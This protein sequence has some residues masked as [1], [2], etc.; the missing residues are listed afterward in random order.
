MKAG[1]NER[2]KVIALGVLILVAI[3]VWFTNRGES[4]PPVSSTP[5][6]APAAP[7]PAARRAQVASDAVVPPRTAPSRSMTRGGS[8]SR[9]QEF[10]PS[11]KPR[12]PDERI[13][14]TTIDPTLRLEL[15]AKLQKVT[16]QGSGRSLF[17]FAA[18]PVPKTPEPK[19]TLNPVQKAMEQ[20]ASGGGPAPGGEAVKPPPPPIPLKFYGYTNPSR[21]G[22][23][24]AFFLDGDDILVA[25]EGEVLKRRYKVVRIGISSAV[26]EDTEQKHQQTLPLVPESMG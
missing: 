2:K 9:S 14:P 25:T 21:Q 13:D 23:K 7:P 16:I 4:G 3:V 8:T 24:R 20:A 5:R 17:D 10:R 18:A 15:L 6:P 22:V 26:V 1:T 12:N 11:L 19:I